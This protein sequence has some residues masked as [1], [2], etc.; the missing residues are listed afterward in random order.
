MAAK[1]PAFLVLL[2]ITM[3]LI[4]SV[5]VHGCGQYSCSSPPPPA[6]PTPPGATC[7]I[8]TA[9]LSVCVDL[10]GYLLKIRLNAP[11]Q[12]CCTLLKGVAN[13]DAALCVC[14]V[15]K[16]LNLISVPVD[17]NLLLNECGM[18]CP[19]GFTCPL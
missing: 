13:A 14:G 15:I 6:V 1:S 17:V 19:P 5:S 10:L 7:P 9:D 12:P 4:F 2:T 16:V 18:T 11:P 8:N 3:T